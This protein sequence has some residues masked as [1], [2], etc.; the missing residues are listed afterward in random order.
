MPRPTNVTA[1]SGRKRRILLTHSTSIR[2]RGFFAQVP[3][4]MIVANKMIMVLVRKLKYLADLQQKNLDAKAGIKRFSERLESNIVW[5]LCRDHIAVSTR[6][7]KSWCTFCGA[8]MGLG[9]HYEQYLLSGTRPNGHSNYTLTSYA[10]PSTM[11]AIPMRICLLCWN[12][13][14]PHIRDPR[15]MITMDH[16]TPYLGVTDLVNIV[17]H[18]LYDAIVKC[19]F[20]PTSS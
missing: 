16:F 14:E 13:F 18:Y 1:N 4:A 12:L 17:H 20:C 6:H 11:F 2:E 19:P 8:G 3:F 10:P 7:A 9:Q 15:P 5:R